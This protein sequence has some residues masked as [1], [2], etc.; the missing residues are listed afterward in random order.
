MDEPKAKQLMKR[1]R[2]LTKK[3]GE[4]KSDCKQDE[5]SNFR[6][7]RESFARQ[8]AEEFE[9][10]Y[11]I[12][13]GK[14][15]FVDKEAAYEHYHDPD[16]R[17]KIRGAGAIQQLFGQRQWFKRTLKEYADM[18]DAE[19]RTKVESTLIKEMLQ[20]ETFIHQIQDELDEKHLD[21][22]DVDARAE[23]TDNL[24]DGIDLSSLDSYGLEEQND[25]Q[26]EES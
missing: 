22:N 1:I 8:L 2:R 24:L 7:Q 10:Y 6:A 25:S 3:I 21:F 17:K 15:Q 26:E 4:A 5:L 12:R 14:T 18:T 23:E 19:L 9:L 13:E 11:I 20:R 16:N